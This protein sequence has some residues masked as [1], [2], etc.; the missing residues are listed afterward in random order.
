[1]EENDT[2]GVWLQWVVLALAA[3][4][5]ALVLHPLCHKHTRTFRNIPSFSY[6]LKSVSVEGVHHNLGLLT[7]LLKYFGKYY[8]LLY[9]ICSKVTIG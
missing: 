6:V 5:I 4:L 8:I 1:M 7:A 2:P 3:A 9:H